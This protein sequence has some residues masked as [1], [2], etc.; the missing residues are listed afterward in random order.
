MRKFISRFWL[1][2]LLFFMYF[3]IVTIIIFSFN[4]SGTMNSWG[5]FSLKWYSTI[6]KDP[7]L[8]K[9]I[10]VTLSVA[11]L[12]ATISTIIGTAAAIGINEFKRF[13]KNL[14]TNL[15]YIP[16]V[17]ADIVTGISLLLCF[18]FTGI[19]RGYFTLL[20]AHITFNIPYVIFSVLPKLK[21]M[22]PDLYD[23]ALDLGA[24]PKRAI[25]NIVVPEILPGIITGFIIAFTLSF[26]DFVVSFFST[27]GLTSNLSIYIYSMARKG[28]RPEINALSAIM[29][30]PI[31]I[32]LIVINVRS[33]LAS[34]NKFK[35]IRSF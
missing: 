34:K 33:N 22:N 28:I 3:P 26:D 30:I 12:S 6:F 19:S 23:A 18:I 31:I 8:I 16:I 32:L 17:N 27:Q 1:A 35:F 10:G 21:Q 20:L 13:P 25:M 9:S 14:I 2:F 24:T 15:T 7:M 4:E 29:F 5:G 11:V